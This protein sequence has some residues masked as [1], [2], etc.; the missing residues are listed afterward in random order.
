MAG[1]ARV[2]GVRLLQRS[3]FALAVL[4]GPGDSPA[5]LVI[6]EV[7]G[8]A[9][10]GMGHAGVARI[11]WQVTSSADLDSAEERLAGHGVRY[12]RAEEMDGGRIE[13]RDP[14]GLS[15]ILFLPSEPSL[16]R[17]PPPFLYRYH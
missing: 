16:A 2:V 12:R 8:S 4:R 1:I 3:A 5:T 17:K 14:D 15:V 10:P 13:A 11:G 9:R 7:S 6:R